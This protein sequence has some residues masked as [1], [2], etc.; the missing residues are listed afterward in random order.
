MRVHFDNWNR[1]RL[2]HDGID[3][4][5]HGRGGLVK[6]GRV[7]RLNDALFVVLN[8][9]RHLVTVI[10]NGILFNDWLTVVVDRKWHLRK[11]RVWAADLVAF[12]VLFS[13]LGASVLEPDFDLPFRESQSLRQFGLPPDCD[14]TTV[15]EL[16]FQLE[17]LMVAVNDSVLVLSS[18]LTWN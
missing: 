18:G 9:R 12:L 6:I 1:S 4:A 3:I 8:L 16:F 5:C 14:V 15:V 13:F 2:L 11:F 17:T 7:V 10:V